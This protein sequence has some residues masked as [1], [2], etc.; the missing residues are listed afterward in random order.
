MTV[1]PK[2]LVV[3]DE[4]EVLEELVETLHLAGF[5]TLSA[6]SAH[7]ALQLISEEE[8]ALVITDLKM[9]DMDGRELLS[10]VVS[11]GHTCPVIV[12]T[13]HGSADSERELLDAGANRV[14]LKPFDPAKLL[15]VIHQLFN[16]QQSKHGK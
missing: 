16:R 13:G 9:P 11:E 15:A 5:S 1:R 14:F 10:A 7:C 3:D 2:I 8:V 6:Q 4:D 12:V